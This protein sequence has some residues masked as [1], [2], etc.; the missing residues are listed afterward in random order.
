MP[1]RVSILLLACLVLLLCACGAQA[2]AQEPQ[3]APDAPVAQ[4]DVPQAPE[5]HH[6]ALFNATVA[7]EERMELQEEGTFLAR[8]VLPDRASAVDYWMIDGERADAG[9]RRFSLEFESSGTD[10]VTAVLREKLHVSCEGCYLQFMDDNGL[11]GGPKFQ[12]VFFEDNYVVPVTSS[13][14]PGGS[15]DCYVAAAVP[16]GMRV[17][18]WIINGVAA[19]FDETVTGFRLFGLTKSLDIQVIFTSGPGTSGADLLL[20]FGRLPD[21]TPK[22]PDDEPIIRDGDG[23]ATDD[24]TPFEGGTDGTEL[25][26]NEAADHTHNWVYDAEHSWPAKC[27]GQ[28]AAGS[29]PSN[30]GTNGRNAYVCSICGATY[31]QD[32]PG[33]HQFRWVSDG[34]G[35]QHYHQCVLCGAIDDWGQCEWLW[36]EDSSKPA[37]GY[38]RC[39]VC[40]YTYV[41]T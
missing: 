15:I 1:K 25:G 35:E 3:A 20:N 40:G 32:V 41:P 34:M 18:Y 21:T 24:W 23:G 5:L 27:P 29:V 33:A 2:P 17:D 37:G 8:A 4:A 7:G 6:I 36:V 38:Y 12:K 39:P 19:A 9:G 16:S 30:T 28:S 13:E 26:S 31:Y 22:F 11:V 14:H 10:A